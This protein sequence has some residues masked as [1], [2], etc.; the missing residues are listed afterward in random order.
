MSQERRR[1]IRWPFLIECSWTRGARI[2]DM[3]TFGCYVDTRI[4][5][6]VGELV[7][8]TAMIDDRTVQIRGTAVNATPGV[9]FGVEF[10]M[11]PDDTTS[12]LHAAL[13]RVAERLDA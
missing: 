2:T 6:K 13:E 7:E 4:A 1:A 8:F 12:V 9:G 3:S 11:L 5:P 10:D